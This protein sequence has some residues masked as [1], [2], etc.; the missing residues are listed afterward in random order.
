MPQKRSSAPYRRTVITFWTDPD[1]KNVLTR[2][3]KLF[4]TYL[5]TNEHSHPCGI[6]RL[7]PIIVADELEFSKDELRRMLTG[8]LAPFATYDWRTEEVFVHA[9][10]E[11]QIDGNGLHG[12]D[13]RIK[14]VTTQLQ[15]THSHPLLEAFR[16]RYGDW[17]LPWV[18]ILEPEFS[19]PKDPQEGASKGLP[20]GLPGGLPVSNG[21]D[22]EKRLNHAEKKGASQGAYQG[23]SQG[24]SQASKQLTDPEPKAIYPP[25]LAET[26]GAR[27]AG[28]REGGK[29]N[30]HDGRETHPDTERLWRDASRG[31]LGLMRTV[32][33]RWH[34]G[35]ER[36]ELS[37]G[38]SVGMGLEFGILSDLLWA[39]EGDVELV[40]WLVREA[41]GV[42]GW[43]SEPR[44][45]Y[46]AI[47]PENLHTAEGEYRRSHT[48]PGPT[49]AQLGVKLKAIAPPTSPNVLQA[50]AKRKLEE[51]RRLA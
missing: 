22:E 14:W 2:D 24:A 50:E 7:R 4:L 38:K 13:N 51:A 15:M 31:G 45:L 5:F 42:M 21:H 46:W 12:Q 10:A 44:T 17:N 28:R 6:Y 3:E 43:D 18:E 8:P 1:I 39:T 23:P 19:T 47:R 37:D 11:H 20:K 33:E 27:E 48:S 32:L 35:Q 26:S 49:L 36:V 40:V 9:M 29:V 41:P 30:E 16:A 34:Q 25:A